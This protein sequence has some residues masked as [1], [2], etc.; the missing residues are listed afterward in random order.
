M[1]EIT[2]PGGIER[3]CLVVVYLASARFLRMVLAGMDGSENP[4][5]MYVSSMI[6]NIYSGT[7][8]GPV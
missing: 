5:S 3:W 7:A 1:G 4:P 2:R 8:S 6:V